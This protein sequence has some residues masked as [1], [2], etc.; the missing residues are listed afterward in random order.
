MIGTVETVL[1][2]AAGS[3]RP[4][5]CQSRHHLRQFI[6]Q[7]AASRRQLIVEAHAH[8]QFVSEFRTQAFQRPAHLGS[9]EMDALRCPS[10]IALTI[11]EVVEPGTAE[12]RWAHSMR[13]GIESGDPPA[14]SGE[15]CSLIEMLLRRSLIY[16]GSTKRVS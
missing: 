3:L 15:G 5:S 1:V 2:H 10:H 12:I 8:Q 13:H 4:K 9:A 6:E 7:F 14:L 11:D 16:A